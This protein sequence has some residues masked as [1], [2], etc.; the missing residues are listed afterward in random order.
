MLRV[1]TGPMATLL[2][3]VTPVRW[4][5]AG[6][7]AGGTTQTALGSVTG[8]PTATQTVVPLARVS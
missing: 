6:T 2:F 7:G 3:H 1:E 4:W 5:C 8:A